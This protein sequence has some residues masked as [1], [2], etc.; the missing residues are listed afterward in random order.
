MAALAL[1]VAGL[2]IRTRRATTSIQ[3]EAAE[4]GTDNASAGKQ[5]ALSGEAPGLAEES[6][7][8]QAV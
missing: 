1:I 5:Y 7:M 3:K 6:K 4:I 8:E 2:I